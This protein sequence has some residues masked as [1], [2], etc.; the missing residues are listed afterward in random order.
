MADSAGC[1]EIFAA[2][3]RRTGMRGKPG[4]NDGFTALETIHQV[5]PGSRRLTITKRIVGLTQ[6]EWEV[7]TPAI[8]H[9]A[10]T[11]PMPSRA[12]QRSPTMPCCAA[13]ASHRD[14]RTDGQPGH[15]EYS[16]PDRGREDR[17]RHCGQAALDRT[18][19]PAS[20]VRRLQPAQPQ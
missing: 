20:T 18:A 7:A 14:E 19:R 5:V 16:D 4:P 6:G 3:Q 12:S 11:R 2:W 8:D 17:S 1:P 13:V 9:D 10:R 15:G